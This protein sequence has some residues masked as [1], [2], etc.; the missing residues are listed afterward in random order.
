[1]DM[2]KDYGGWVY[3]GKIGG[4][5]MSKIHCMNFLKN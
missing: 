1:M 2:R 4:G 3:L 5:D